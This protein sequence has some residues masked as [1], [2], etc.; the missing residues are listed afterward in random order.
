MQRFLKPFSLLASAIPTINRL[1][2]PFVFLAFMTLGTPVK[3]ADAWW[4]Q[5]SHLQGYRQGQDQGHKD[6]NE[7]GLIAGEHRG[8]FW[9]VIGGVLAACAGMLFS[10]V[11]HNAI[12]T[13]MPWRIHSPRH[14]VI[15]H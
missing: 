1:F 15:F 5:D 3:E 14:L 4:N 6:G 12:R 13:V 9:G 8:F 10:W 7:I 2:L 11:S